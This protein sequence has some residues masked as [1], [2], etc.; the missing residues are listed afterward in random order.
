MEINLPNMAKLVKH[1]SPRLATSIIFAISCD[2]EFDEIHAVVSQAIS[3]R[4]TNPW[5]L[6]VDAG[7]PGNAVRHLL[8]GHEP[9]AS[10]LAEICAA[11]DLEFYIG[12][13]RGEASALPLS[14]VPDLTR[15]GKAEL[16]HRGLAKCAINGWGK[17]QPLSEP[18]PGPEFVTDEAAFYVSATGQLMIPEGIDGG[19]FCLVSPAREPREGDRV[20]LLDGSG[21]ATIKRLLKIGEKSVT[22]RGWMPVQN[23]QQ[24]SFEDERFTNYIKAMY[25]VIAVFRGKPGSDDCE[26]VPD[27][28]PP[29]HA[30]EPVSGAV[31]PEAVT[32]LLGLPQNADSATVVATISE[33]LAGRGTA[34]DSQAVTRD[35]MSTIVAE[36]LRAEMK[37]MR[38]GLADL[39]VVLPDT[40]DGHSVRIAGYV[41]NGGRI[42]FDDRLGQAPAPAANRDGMIA[43]E[44]RGGA[45]HGLRS[46]DRVYF[47]PDRPCEP[48]ERIGRLVAAKVSDGNVY[49]GTLQHGDNEGTWTLDASTSIRNVTL[50]NVA[51]LEWVCFG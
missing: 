32:S 6:A 16:P 35:E 51:A 21:A 42:I 13:P 22:L 9:K 49:I 30:R 19:T 41:S 26:Y 33:Q 20:W 4:G 12:P 40:A 27:P 3:R 1:N 25:P 34:D 47:R 29:A 45:V 5:R 37:A 46:G 48:D 23:R 8:D 14:P 10:R 28:K 7:L 15:F 50:S 44:I 38:D 17:D 18:L 2:M 11:L 39:A 31:V 43:I 36:T 24:K